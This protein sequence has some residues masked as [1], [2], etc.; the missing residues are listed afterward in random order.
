MSWCRIQ[1]QLHYLNEYLGNLTEQASRALA[2]IV[3]IFKKLRYSHC[4]PQEGPATDLGFLGFS[5]PQEVGNYGIS[6]LSVV[7]NS[8]H[9]TIN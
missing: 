3:W 1:H 7:L 2:L 5:A 9:S 6:T 8:L 4:L